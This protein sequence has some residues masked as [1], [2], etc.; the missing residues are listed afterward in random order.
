M[1][2]EIYLMETSQRIV[3]KNASNTYTKGPFFCVYLKDENKVYKYPVAHIFNV[4]ETYNDLHSIEQATGKE[5]DR[6]VS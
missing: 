1:K 2:V 5:Q 4:A 3:F 6:E